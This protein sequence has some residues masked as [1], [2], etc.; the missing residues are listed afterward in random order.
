MFNELRFILGDSLYY[1]SFQHLYK[2]WELKHIDEYKLIEA[3][4][5]NVGEELDWFFDPWLHTTR[6]LDYGISSFKKTKSNDRWDIELGIKNNGMRFLP[7]LIETEYEDGS[8][9]RSWWDRHL[10]RFQDT[11]RYT[12]NK[13]PLKVVMDPEVQTID[14]DLRNNSTKMKKTIL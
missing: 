2:K 4:E 13:K 7:L 8:T 6:H 10:W 1:S 3:F 14:M 12:T 9:S 5:E 11:L